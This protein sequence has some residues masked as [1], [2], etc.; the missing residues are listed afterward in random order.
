[1]KIPFLI[2]G[3]QVKKKGP[4][5]ISYSLVLGGRRGGREGLQR[6]G[7]KRRLGHDD[8]SHNCWRGGGGGG[9]GKGGGI[10]RRQGG[11]GKRQTRAFNSFLE[12]RKEGKVFLIVLFIPRKKGKRR[13]ERVYEGKQEGLTLIGGRTFS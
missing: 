13:G 3:T 4:D 1:M 5:G 12:Q 10:G 9:G 7:K 11:G 2:W 6:K 8:K